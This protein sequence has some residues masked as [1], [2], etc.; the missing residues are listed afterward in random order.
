M[1]LLLQSALI[2]ALKYIMKP[3]YSSRNIASLQLRTSQAVLIN[4]VSKQHLLSDC[5]ACEGK[6][7][8]TRSASSHEWGHLNKEGHM[9]LQCLCQHNKLMISGDNW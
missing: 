1:P 5:D 9:K 4:F 8:S 3:V 6:I 2:H 7:Q